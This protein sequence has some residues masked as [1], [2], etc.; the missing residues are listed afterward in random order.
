MKCSLL[1]NG[2]FALLL[3]LP[4]TAVA[5]PA[6]V[7]DRLFLSLYPEPDSTSERLD[8]LQS[9]DELER[10]GSVEDGFAQVE[11]PDGTIGWVNQEFLVD[12]PPARVRIDEVEAERNE[13]AERLA[14]RD[15]EIASLERERDKLENELADVQQL[16]DSKP[17]LEADAV[18]TAEEMEGSRSAPGQAEGE[19]RE[20]EITAATTESEPVVPAYQQPRFMGLLLAFM[21]V[22][23]LIGGLIGWLLRERRIRERLGGLSL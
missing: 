5:E 2:C 9:G 20:A 12:S 7:I 14:N 1:R 22:G 8:L 4:L 16:A 18:L 13:L 11:T 6:W 17:E 21:L 19:A 23:G 3:L 15:R 10:L